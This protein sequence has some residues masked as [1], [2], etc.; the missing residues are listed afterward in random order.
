MECHHIK[1]VAN[2]RND[3]YSNLIYLS[4]DAHKLVT[5]TQE[6]TIQMDL[7]RMR[8]NEKQLE[9]VNKLRKQAGLAEIECEH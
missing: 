7:R 6:K 4:G 1:P 2:G 3:T 9:K 8:L 5:V